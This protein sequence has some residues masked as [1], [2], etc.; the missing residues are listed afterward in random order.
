MHG[1][2]ERRQHR[3]LQIRL[4]LECAAALGRRR[5]TYRTVT[6]DISAGGVC[7]EADRDEFP[8]GTAL[9]M[10][11]GVPPGDGHSPYPGRVR[12]TGE[13]V[14]VDRLNDDGSLPRFR[15]AAHFSKPLKLAF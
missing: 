7:F 5:V 9:E 6:H 8:V 14:R 11:L 10:E 12:G 15:M 3:R 13:V 4:P 1:P 2:P